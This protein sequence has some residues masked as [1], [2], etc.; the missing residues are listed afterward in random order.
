MENAELIKYYQKSVKMCDK[1]SG[2]L[3]QI[4]DYKTLSVIYGRN[5]DKESYIIDRSLIDHLEWLKTVDPSKMVDMDI[6]MD[7]TQNSDRERYETLAI[8]M[9]SIPDCYCYAR[10][11][12]LRETTVEIQIFHKALFLYLTKE[13][14]VKMIDEY[15]NMVYYIINTLDEIAFDIKSSFVEDEEVEA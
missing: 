6:S 12:N 11:Y 9:E 5:Y 14:Q 10:E 2:I 13:E 4:I 3:N 15:I 7:E 8:Y 1:Y